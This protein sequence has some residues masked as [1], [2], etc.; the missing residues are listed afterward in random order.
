[1]NRKHRWWYHGQNYKS[2]SFGR[3]FRHASRGL[4]LGALLEAHIR[5]QVIFGIFVVLLGLLCNLSFFEWGAVLLVSVLVIILEFL[6]SAIEA[7]A[8]AV[9][10]E[11]N[12]Y[13][14]RSKDLSAAAVLVAS[15]FALVVGLFIFLP[16][17]GT[18]ALWLGNSM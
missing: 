7:L 18:I 3:S 12:E 13:I 4:L 1:M 14:Q 6:N 11:Y 16:H 17:V 2:E 8:D 10:P 5:R 15:L 9:H